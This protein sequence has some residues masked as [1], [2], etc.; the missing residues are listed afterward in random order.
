MK[1]FFFSNKIAPFGMS[2]TLLY[3]KAIQ[4]SNIK[5]LFAWHQ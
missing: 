2:Y 4:K 1:I 3:I 5:A